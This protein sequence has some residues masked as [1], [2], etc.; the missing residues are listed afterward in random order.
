MDI[1]DNNGTKE[2]ASLKLKILIYTIP[3]FVDTYPLCI[4]T[5]PDGGNFS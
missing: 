2:L 4:D 5:R 1:S 3:G